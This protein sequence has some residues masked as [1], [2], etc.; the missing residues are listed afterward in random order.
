VE[1]FEL[2]AVMRT[3]EAVVLKPELQAIDSLS[4]SKQH[5][6]ERW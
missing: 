1:N 4:S 3:P 6:L 2:Y 5:W